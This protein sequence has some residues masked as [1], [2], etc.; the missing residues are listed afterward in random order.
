MRFDDAQLRRLRELTL[1]GD[2]Y[3]LQAARHDRERRAAPRG[4][5]RRRFHRR[6]FERA[7]E[8]ALRD[9]P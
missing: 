4:S 6:A 7:A 9:R 5:S 3:A 8:A 2:P 1:F